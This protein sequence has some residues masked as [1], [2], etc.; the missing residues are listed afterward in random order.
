[1]FV[2][3]SKQHGSELNFSEMSVELDGI[4]CDGKSKCSLA[5]HQRHCLLQASAFLLLVQMPCLNS[6][7]TWKAPSEYIYLKNITT[8]TQRIAFN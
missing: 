1:M 6:P 5:H 7:E 3:Y 4:C 8:H 2:P